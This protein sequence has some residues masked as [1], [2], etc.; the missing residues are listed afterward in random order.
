MTDIL[1]FATYHFFNYIRKL[2]D[3][4]LCGKYYSLD[5]LGLHLR[6]RLTCFLTTATFRIL[7]NSPIF[8][9]NVVWSVN[10]KWAISNQTGVSMKSKEF[11]LDKAKLTPGVCPYCSVGCGIMGDYYHQSP[12]KQQRTGCRV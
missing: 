8:F 12:A 4:P 10:I 5:V 9:L 6:K 1:K 11:R 3:I 7:Y 2:L